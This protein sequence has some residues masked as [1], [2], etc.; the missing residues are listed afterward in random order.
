MGQLHSYRSAMSLFLFNNHGGTAHYYHEHRTACTNGFIVD[1]EPYNGICT[2]GFGG[3]HQLGHSRLLAFAQH[4]FVAFDATAESITQICK[5]I[6]KYI[7]SDNGFSRYNLFV[8]KNGVT[9][10]SGCCC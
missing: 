6:F 3:F 2:N 1:V 10:N 4:F 7:G 8:L 5:E 9:L